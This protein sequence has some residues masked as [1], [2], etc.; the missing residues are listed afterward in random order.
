MEWEENLKD[1]MLQMDG[2]DFETLYQICSTA[3][4]EGCQREKALAIEAYRLRCKDLFGNR[5]M[6]YTQ[7]KPHTQRICAG[8]CSY[9]KRYAFELYKLE[10]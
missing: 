7:S 6:N 1:K 3:Y 2:N 10:N 9:V 4:S 5:C 8:D